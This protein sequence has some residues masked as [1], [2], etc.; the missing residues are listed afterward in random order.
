VILPKKRLGEG[1]R[2]FR[3]RLPVLGMILAGLG[4]ALIAQAALIP[5]KAAV[6]QVLLD[7]AF[8]QTLDDGEPHKPWR[9]AD[10]WPVARIEVPRLGKRAIILNGVSGEA[11][12]F[13]PGH[14][15]GTPEAGAP[16]MAV[17]AA[18]RDT[19]FAFLA[20]VRSGDEIRVTGADGVTH[21]F[22][23]EDGYVARWDASGIPAGAFGPPR[24][25]LTTCWPFDSIVRGD[26]RYVL[27]AEATQPAG[28]M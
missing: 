14:V 7:R 11:M 15:G 9:W 1:R 24:I 18:H 6:A 4:L 20:D 25:A 27:I 17:Y 28:L 16:G 22:T 2:P 26:E 19:H 21:S 13:G 10:T 5:A 23:A 12:A 3:S 8:E